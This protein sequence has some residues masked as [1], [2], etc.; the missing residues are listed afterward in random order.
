MEKQL[1]IVNENKGV[2][3]LDQYPL[4]IEVITIARR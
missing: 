4:P 1:T 2:N 3:A